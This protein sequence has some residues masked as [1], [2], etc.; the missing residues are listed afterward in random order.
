MR[1]IDISRLLKKL[2][3]IVFLLL[4]YGAFSQIITQLTNNLVSDRMGDMSGNGFRIAWPRSGLR[5]INADGTGSN[6]ITTMNIAALSING[7]GSK[8]A[9]TSNTDH[10]KREAY[11]IN[12]DG[13]GLLRLTNND[14]YDDV[15]GISSDGS[16][17]VFQREL[18]PICVI[19]SDGTNFLQLRSDPNDRWPRISGDGNVVVFSN[20]ITYEIYKINSDGTGFLQLTSGFTL[21]QVPDISDDG[22][23]IVFDGD[24]GINDGVWGINSD[25]TGLHFIAALGSYPRLNSDGS[26]VSYTFG[27][28][29]RR[30]NFDGTNDISIDSMGGDFVP[31]NSTGSRIAYTCWD[32][33]YEICIWDENGVRV[34]TPAGSSVSV[35]SGSGMEVMYPSV[36]S[37]CTTEFTY[38]A[39]GRDL[40]LG[41]WAGASNLHYFITT[42]CSYTG[43]VEVRIDYNESDFFNE[44]AIR[45]N[46]W[47]AGAWADVTTVLDQGINRRKS[48]PGTSSSTIRENCWTAGDLP[49]SAAWSRPS[50]SMRL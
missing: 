49:Y 10:P 48:G 50:R 29:V 33:D 30:V 32:D 38:N 9:F 34:S 14:Q 13:T 1:C 5:I 11:V 25:G 41:K 44:P 28:S 18:G 37:A 35:S 16:K 42:T 7:D 15:Y 21:A 12:S 23:K 45:L 43:P 19:N 22:T 31:I 6:L 17:I 24:N 46:H 47:E 36:V 20:Q 26:I 39:G 8:I 2:I 27:F 4:P 40:P 3:I